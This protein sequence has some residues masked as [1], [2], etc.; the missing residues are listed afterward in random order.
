MWIQ[1]LGLFWN[2]IIYQYKY[3]TFV[4]SRYLNIFKNKVGKNKK[5][6]F[7]FKMINFNF[8]K[9][10]KKTIHVLKN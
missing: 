10:K 1:I 6:Y 5:V 9:F 7:R 3:L 2:K 4:L 8:I